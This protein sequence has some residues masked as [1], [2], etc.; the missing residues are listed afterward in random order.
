MSNVILLWFVRNLLASI[1]IISLNIHESA[2]IK[3]MKYR[4]SRFLISENIYLAESFSN[5]SWTSMV[6]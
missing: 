3:D 6:K 1:N 5:K 2:N 4:L